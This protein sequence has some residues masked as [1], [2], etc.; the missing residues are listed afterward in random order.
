MGFSD[1]ALPEDSY[2][3]PR[4]SLSNF[5]FGGS[6]KFSPAQQETDQTPI[7]HSLLSHRTDPALKGYESITAQKVAN[8]ELVCITFSFRCDGLAAALLVH[9]V[10][11]DRR[12][13]APAPSSQRSI[14][15]L[16]EHHSYSPSP[17]SVLVSLEPP[18]RPNYGSLAGYP[19]LAPASL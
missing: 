4:L 8:R 13:S 7:D 15:A 12:Y 19:D 5:R 18:P 10:T 6:C 1:A 9:L 14:Q 2:S 3:Q 17:V 16:S 11:Q